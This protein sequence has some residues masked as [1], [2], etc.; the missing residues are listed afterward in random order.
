[1]IPKSCRLSGQ[2]HAPE[3]AADALASA[4]AAE[5]ALTPAGHMALMRACPAAVKAATA[6]IRPG[7][8]APLRRAR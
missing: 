4:C 3:Q 1:M 5:T 6:A 2:D 7:A 8:R